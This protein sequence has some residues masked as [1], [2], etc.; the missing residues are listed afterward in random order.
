M[1]SEIV[2]NRVAFADNPATPAFRE[3]EIVISGPFCFRN[4]YFLQ[5]LA[6]FPL[7]PP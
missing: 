6:D 2:A 4:D 1:L 5:G 7:T 3:E